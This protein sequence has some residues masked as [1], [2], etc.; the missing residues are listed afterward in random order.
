VMYG[1]PKETFYNLP[2]KVII[3]R[4][5]FKFSNSK[6]LWHTLKT[7]FFLRQKIKII[8]PKSILSFGEY[9]NNF[10]LLSNLDLKYSIFVSDRSQ[11]DKSL[12]KLHDTLRQKLY[13]RAKGVICQTQ[14]AKAIYEKMF[15]HDNFTIIGNPI[16]KVKSSQIV[17]E[18]I[19]LSV[20][21]LIDSKHFDELIEIF[22]DVNQ[23]HW[24]LII[25][26]DNA[27]KQ[28]NMSVLQSLIQKLGMQNKIVLAGKQRDVD[29]YY[30]KSKIFAFT[31]SSEGFPNAVGEAM[32]AGLPVVA[33]DCTAGPSDLI[34]HNETGYLIDLHNKVEF[35]N[36]LKRLMDDE[37]LRQEMSLKAKQKIKQNSIKVIGK[38]FEQVLLS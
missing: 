3:H 21:R 8:N 12:G 18:N 19:V 30:N 20:G 32:S 29:S 1:I 9:W 7:L 36:K 34:H 5:N 17:K 14:K 24:K 4:P 22:A 26:G 11:P 33:Y 15:K 23:N 16:K 35:K 31:S 6:R 38:K 10:V 13:P 2:E 27:L 25:V 37:N 28:D